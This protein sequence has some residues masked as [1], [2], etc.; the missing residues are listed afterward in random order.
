MVALSSLC[1]RGLGRRL[2]NY[3]RPSP[4][5]SNRQA[6]Q[7]VTTKVRR[8]PSRCFD[9]FTNARLLPTWVPG[10]KRAK[11]VR[12]GEGGRP[13]EVLYEFDATLSYSLVYR[14]DP[15]NRRVAWIPGLGKK[16][17]V[18]GWAQFDEDDDG[19]LMQYAID[20][21]APR[22]G[23]PARAPEEVAAE[24]VRAFVKWVEAGPR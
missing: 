10:L 14:Y 22:R 3:A 13:L 9:S 24:I 5:C 20:T 18:S 21:P 1:F 7:V 17:A 2:S 16:E 8:T 15:E 23:K 11:V 19:C 4:V 6:V 12:E